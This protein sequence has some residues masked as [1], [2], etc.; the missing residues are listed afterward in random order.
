M[1]AVIDV[2]GSSGPSNA[3]ASF[4]HFL[5]LVKTRPRA[6]PKA[7]YIY[8]GGLWSLSRGAGGLIRGRM[9]DSPGQIIW[10]R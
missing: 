2:L 6:A 8:T 10:R 5:D 4:H 9:R 7:M 3:L 1:A